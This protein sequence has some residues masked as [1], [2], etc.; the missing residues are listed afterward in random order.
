MELL[1]GLYKELTNPD[2]DSATKVAVLDDIEYHVHKYDN[3]VYFADLG[4]IA[5]LTELLN[6]SSDADVLSGVAITLGSAAQR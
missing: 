5:R 2:T 1:T 4:G 6:S 3:A